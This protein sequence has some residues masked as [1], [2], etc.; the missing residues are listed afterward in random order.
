MAGEKRR[1]ATQMTP[2]EIEAFLESERTLVVVVEDGF[3]RVGSAGPSIDAMGPATA[4]SVG[5]PAA[6]HAARPP[7]RWNIS[8]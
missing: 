1:A 7:S 8:S 3:S 4:Y 5:S 2:D 6:C